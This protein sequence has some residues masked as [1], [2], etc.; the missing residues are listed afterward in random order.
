MKSASA[1]RYARALVAV[2]VSRGRAEQAAG[3][4]AR[5]AA[6]FA[7]PDGERA[8]ALLQSSRVPASERAA[9]FGEIP[10][11]LGLGDETAGLVRTFARARALASLGPVADRARELAAEAA[12]IAEVELRTAR[13]LSSEMTSRIAAAAEKLLGRQVKLTVVEDAKLVAGVVMRAGN[14]IRDGSLAGRMAAAREA[15]G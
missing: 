13:P 9:L 10:T 15:L 11:A 5:A 3:E 2:A 14:S 12:G 4:V 7:T 6:F 8:A 1:G